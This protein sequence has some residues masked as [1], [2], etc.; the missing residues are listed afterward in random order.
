M[1][2]VYSFSMSS[3]L[4]T[5]LLLQLLA[6]YAVRRSS[7]DLYH[8]SYQFSSKDD[9]GTESSSGKEDPVSSDASKP[10]SDL[11]P[12]V[13]IAILA[14]N[15][16]YL[17]PNFLGYIDGLDYPKDRISLWVRTD[18]NEDNTS[19]ILQEWCAGVEPLY[20]NVDFE[21][22]AEWLYPDRD[23]FQWPD[24]RYDHITKLRQQALDAA[25][26]GG[27]NYL[28]FVDCD[29]FL[30]NEKTL[31]L[32]IQQE[33]P[34]VAPMLLPDGDNT[35][36]NFWCGQDSSGYYL[37]TPDYVPT[38]MRERVGCL[39]VPV[40]HSVYLVDLRREASSRLAYWPAPSGF[41]GPVD[42]VVMFAFSAKREGLGIFVLNTEFFGYLIRP[43]SYHS[44]E[45]AADVFLN[46]KL[47][48]LVNHPPV[49]YSE[50]VS[51]SNK[52]PENLNLD[53]VFMISLARRPDRRNRMVS[54]LNELNINFTLF[55]AVDGKKL[56]QSYVDSLGIRY[57]PGWRDPWG[58]RPMT[59]GEVG[60]FLS[61]YYI[62]ER[63]VSENMDRVLVLEDD[64]DF[65]AFFA[66]RLKK[67][68]NETETLKLNW[69]LIYV[70]R[71]A[72]DWDNEIEVPGSSMLV[73]P[74]YSY[75][76]LGYLLSHRG[77]EK[78]INAKPFEKMLPVDEYIPIL[79]RKHPQ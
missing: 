32:L 46:F 75:W 52:E 57:L 7:C 23:P 2:T 6:L 58:E 61:H 26:A 44:L 5:A 63:V 67:L 27:H 72:L 47:K 43:I 74:D 73:V 62:W 4:C 59:M 1:L 9:D 66:S 35:F 19:A 22:S 8:A 45:Y 50:H 40:V 36:S 69:D 76:T 25:R 65:E 49:P 33:K 3:R 70:G 13:L 18:H 53:A 77:A 55:D 51:P 34:I 21:S 78:L 41:E 20:S 12:S 48:T 11:R 14:R 16:G 37:R 30:V 39:E 10:A 29:N 38:L 60:C 79:F 42:E 17:L 31:S 68:L 56:N 71:K 28:F 64:V 54:A 24:E 15:H